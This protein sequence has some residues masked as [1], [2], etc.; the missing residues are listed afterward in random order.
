M[1]RLGRVGRE[2]PHDSHRPWRGSAIM[3][4]PA[5]KMPEARVEVVTSTRSVLTAVRYNEF[6]PC[7]EATGFRLGR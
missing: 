1:R 3:G 4:H 7:G 6:C 2:Q 5:Y